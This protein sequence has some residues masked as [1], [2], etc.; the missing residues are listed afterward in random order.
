MPKKELT[1]G[2][3]IGSSSVRAALFD[4]AGNVVPKTII[5]LERTL[6][7]TNDGGSEI[8]ADV[9]FRQFVMA[10]DE[11]VATAGKQSADISHVASCTFWH[12]LLGVDR[13]GRPTT[14]VLGWADNRSRNFVKI[15]RKKLDELD[16][17]NR[18]GARFHSSFWPAKLLWLRKE[19]Q[20]SWANTSTWLSIGDY[21]ASR[22][23]D[24]TATSVSIASGTGI[25]NIREN[26]WDTEM[27]QYLRLKPINLAPIAADGANYT[28]TSKY[29]GRWPQLADAQWFLP[30]A[31]GAANNIG[32]GCI[33][34]TR[35]A[36]MVGT[37][38]AMRVSLEGKPPD[39]IPNGLWCYRIDR[40]RVLLGGALSDGG[41]LIDWL[42]RNL[43]L[44]KNAED[45]VSMRPPAAHGLAF[46][47][48]LAGERS[49]GYDENAHGAVL[50]L[51]M[52][53]NAVDILQ[54][55]MESVAFRFAEIL[56]Q[57]ESVIPV[58]EM[59]ASGGAMA[60][61]PA[62]VQIISDVLGRDIDFSN[63]PE[64]SMRGAVLLAL[65]TTGKI[66][67]TGINASDDKRAVKADHSRHE[68]Y[69]RAKIEHENIYQLS[70]RS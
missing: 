68:V 2:L 13:M 67:I 23:F 9:A 60:A 43:R 19:F 5:K 50:G 59:I 20:G 7:V 30:I 49:T 21:F 47:P 24:E 69:K 33:D 31:D 34:K 35:A 70:R 53:N 65:E 45:L 51:S 3:D 63:H 41:G 17:H 14:P 25:F 12:S 18:T 16:V 22:L 8:D 4:H 39:Q 29:K 36:L 11:V 38:G 64:A 40:K 27:C 26:D 32:S 6:R 58:R 52:A 66:S 10:V 48:F 56:K 55:A 1:L 46:L 42:R 15:L 28:L 44:P 61:S 62:W 37:S 57:I 54:A